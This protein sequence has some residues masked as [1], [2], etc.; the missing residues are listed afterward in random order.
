MSF[1][2]TKIEE[3]NSL[4]DLWNTFKIYFCALTIIKKTK[5]MSLAKADF[6]SY[7][8]KIIH[9]WQWLKLRYKKKQVLCEL[10][11]NFKNLIFSC[12]LPWQ[13]HNININFTSSCNKKSFFVCENCMKNKYIHTHLCYLVLIYRKKPFSVQITNI[14]VILRGS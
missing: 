2:Y 11:K 13:Q 4:C 1:S 9:G 5:E 14:F 3:K 7:E 8:I 10:W 12:F 6:F